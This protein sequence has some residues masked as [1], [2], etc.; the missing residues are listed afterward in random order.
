MKVSKEACA[1]A[2][3]EKAFKKACPGWW[4][5]GL[6]YGKDGDPPSLEGVIV[7]MI[8]CWPSFLEVDLVA[9]LRRIV[10]FEAAN[11]FS[12]WLLSFPKRATG[13]RLLADLANPSAWAAV[14]TKRRAG[15]CQSGAAGENRIGP[16]TLKPLKAQQPRSTPEATWPGVVGWPDG[17]RN[18]DR[19]RAFILAP[20]FPWPSRNV[21]RL[22]G[23]R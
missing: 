23:L 11:H 7:H 8:Y 16:S 14:R 9:Q 10:S 3:M 13:Q 6:L 4:I 21:D 12:K 17:Q 20:V 18:A 19:L 22:S 15:R 1:F 2:S 5:Q